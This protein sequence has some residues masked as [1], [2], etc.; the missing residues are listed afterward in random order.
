[1]GHSAHVSQGP[2]FVVGHVQVCDGVQSGHTVQV[3]DHVLA[4]VQAV[5]LPNLGVEA[6]H[7]LDLVVVEVNAPQVRQSRQ[8][9]DFFYQIRGEI[10]RLELGSKS[11]GVVD[12]LDL[13]FTELQ[14]LEL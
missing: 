5:D 1:M 7:V 14:S 8:V 6:L 3:L 13:V 4:Q 9:C 11:Y 12:I 2:Q 10:G